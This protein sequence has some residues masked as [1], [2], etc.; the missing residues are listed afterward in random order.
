MEIE[1]LQSELDGLDRQKQAINA[2]MRPILDQIEQYNREIGV[3]SAQKDR[4]AV[5]T[6]LV[7]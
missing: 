2:A 1:Q 3:K 7:R 4:I 5:M 6:D